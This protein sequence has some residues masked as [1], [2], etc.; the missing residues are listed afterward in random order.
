MLGCTCR[1]R[2]SMVPPSNLPTDSLADP[3]LWNRTWVSWQDPPEKSPGVDGPRLVREVLIASLILGAVVLTVA[4]LLR[5]SS[6]ILKLPFSH[7]DTR[8][9]QNPPHDPAEKATLTFTQPY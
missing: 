3:A 2:Q 4:V 1:Y 7:E 8:K 6:P 5:L 9:R